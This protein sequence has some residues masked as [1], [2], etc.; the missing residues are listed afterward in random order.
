MLSHTNKAYGKDDIKMKYFRK[1]IGNRL[2]QG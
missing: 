1:K 2:L